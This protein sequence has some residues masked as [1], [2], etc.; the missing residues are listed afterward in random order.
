MN[1]IPAPTAIWLCGTKSNCCVLSWL[2][3]LLKKKSI[4]S[5]IREAISKGDYDKAAALKLEMGK[6]I[7]ELKVLYHDYK[8]NIID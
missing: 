5:G 8:Q 3:T 2:K 7:E 1:K 6:V 4:F